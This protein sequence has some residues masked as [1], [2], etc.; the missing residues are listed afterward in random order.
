MRNDEWDAHYHV[1]WASAGHAD[2]A[3]TARPELHTGT[4]GSPF[5][6]HTVHRLDADGN[7]TGHP[8]AWIVTN[9]VEEPNEALRYMAHALEA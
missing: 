7:R 1:S 6:V 9:D 3:A 8:V 4:D 2:D 5:T